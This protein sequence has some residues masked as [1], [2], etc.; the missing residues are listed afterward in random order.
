VGHWEWASGYAYDDA[1]NRIVSTSGGTV[2]TYDGNGQR[3]LKNGG[4]EYFYFGGQPIAELNNNTWSDYIFAGS[5]RI[6]V[7]T[8]AGPGDQNAI[9]A[10]NTNYY[11]GDQLGSSR[12]MT[13]GT[14]LTDNSTPAYAFYAP[15]GQLVEGD[16]PS[17][18]KF[19]GK[20]RDS[21]TNLDYFGAR[22]YASNMGRWMSPDWSAAPQPVPYAHLDNPQTLNLYAYVDNNP[23]SQIDADG[24]R[25]NNDGQ[26]GAVGCED[27]GSTCAAKSAQQQNASVAVAP[28]LVG[29]IVSAATATVAAT[30]A[31]GA[32]V[33]MS[34]DALITRTADAYVA[35][36]NDEANQQ[37]ADSRAAGENNEKLAPKPGSAGGPGSGRRATPDQRDQ[38]LQENGGKC[39]FCGRPATQ[40]DHAVPRSRGGDTTPENMQPACSHCNAQKGAKTTQEYLDWLGSK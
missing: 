22:Y 34:A 14:V 32:A 24:H 6:A 39:V 19:T 5:R 33:V 36:K 10:A 21:E 40:A 28:T 27:N 1:E 2:Y 15:F 7:S 37:A 38:A 23:A 20:E 29:E 31:A 13:T 35:N 11:H 9:L 8:S 16:V 30:V 3:V 12:M 17:H 4:T 26:P 25:P 18:Y